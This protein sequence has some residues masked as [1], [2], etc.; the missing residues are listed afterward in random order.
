[1]KSRFFQIIIILIILLNIISCDNNYRTILDINIFNQKA[2]YSNKEKPE[3]IKVKQLKICKELNYETITKL[4]LN[5]KISLISKSQDLFQQYYK[6]KNNFLEEY[7]F[8]INYVLDLFDLCSDDI[9]KDTTMKD[10][11]KNVFGTN[12]TSFYSGILLMFSYDDLLP[13]QKKFEIFSKMDTNL[14]KN[15]FLLSETDIQ[16]LK[17]SISVCLNKEKNNDIKNIFNNMLSSLK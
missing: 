4:S 3:L 10:E 14:K 12:N 1:M 5:E 8:M 6:Y 2:L 15:K 11:E 17:Q 13:V 16:N 9:K 7:L